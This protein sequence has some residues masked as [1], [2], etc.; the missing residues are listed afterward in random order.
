VTAPGRQPAL[1]ARIQALVQVESL[2]D[3]ATSL[4]LFKG[5]N[6]LHCLAQA[7]LQLH[8]RPSAIGLCAGTWP[9]RARLL[10]E[11]RA[12]MR[13]SGW[14]GRWFRGIPGLCLWSA[15]GGTPAW[16]RSWQ[17]RRSGPL[18][19]TAR[20]DPAG[21][22]T[23]STTPPFR[24]PVRSA[25]TLPGTSKHSA[26]IASVSPGVPAE[27]LRRVGCLAARVAQRLVVLG[28]PSGLGP[29]VAGRTARTGTGSRPAPRRTRAALPGRPSQSPGAH[30]ATTPPGAGPGDDRAATPASPQRPVAGSSGPTP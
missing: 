25:R 6:L 23:L 20:T 10:P 28:R 1:P 21:T 13:G 30:P 4:V 7:R 8:W 17:S 9:S 15:D 3:D 19:R 27:E 14:G 5:G 16:C 29:L 24:Q 12:A 11:D 2:F 22:T 26:S 18:R